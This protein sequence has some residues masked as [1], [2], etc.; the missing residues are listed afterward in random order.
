MMRS[1]KAVF[2]WARAAVLACSA[3]AALA[4]PPPTAA[5]PAP[6]MA[7]APAVPTV[8][9]SVRAPAAYAEAARGRPPIDQ[10]IIQD[11]LEMMGNEFTDLVRVYLEDTP[12]SRLVSADRVSPK[13]KK[14]CRWMRSP[15]KPLT[16]LPTA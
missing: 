10:E 8:V 3:L 14:R 4:G 7:P 13:R 11:L 1:L 5:P 15:R 12:K 6:V 2:R 16:A 9:P